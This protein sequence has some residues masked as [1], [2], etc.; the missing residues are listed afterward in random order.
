MLPHQLESIQH[1]T[2][3]INSNLQ[4]TALSHH[5]KSTTYN[6]SSST[7]IYIYN[8]SSSALESTHTELFI[9][10]NLHIQ[11]FLST[12]IYNIHHFFI[13]LNLQHT[14][15]QIQATNIILG[16]IVMVLLCCFNYMIPGQ[17]T[18]ITSPKNNISKTQYIVPQDQNIE[19]KVSDRSCIKA[20]VH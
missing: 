1:T 5:L 19:N 12:Q 4:H 11:N 9:N 10:S 18:L 6:T 16:A 17:N 15:S 13:N 20:S 2:L 7:H 14:T 8:T 3:I